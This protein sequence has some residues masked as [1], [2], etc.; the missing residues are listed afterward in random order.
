MKKL[1]AFVLAAV[2]L[3]GAISAAGAAFS[4]A[5]KIAENKKTAVDYVSE[6]KII[7]GFPD[8]SFKPQ[9]TLTRAQAAKILCAA[10]EGAEKGERA[11]QDRHRLFR[12]ARLALGG[13]VHRVLCR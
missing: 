12:R 4:D 6:K 3:L 2:L 1:I 10:L 13:E 9:D 11:Y 7:S 5:D 8:G